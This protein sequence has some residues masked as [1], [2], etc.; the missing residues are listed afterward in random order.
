[1]KPQFGRAVVGGLVGTF[2]MTLIMMLVAPMMGVYMDIAKSLS[3][4]MAP[5]TQ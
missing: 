1:M 5:R 4:M 3:A 2:A